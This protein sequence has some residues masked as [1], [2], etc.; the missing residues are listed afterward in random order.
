[1]PMPY[2]A[3][4]PGLIEQNV[5][6]EEVHFLGSSPKSFPA[7]H[8]PTYES[9]A[10]RRNYEPTSPVSLTS[11]GE[12]ELRPLGDI[13]LARSG[14]KGG[15]VNIGIFVHTDKEWDWLRSFLTSA[16]MQELV[17]DDWKPEFFIERIEF[18]HLKA[19]HFVI[20]GI[21]G[22]G[23]SSSSRLD[24]LGKAFGEYI[25]DKWVPVPVQFLK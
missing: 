12:T 7:G 3:Y 23:V 6:N 15:N 8:P 9:L 19:V 5:L 14:D 11:F 20:Y 21:L 22:R 16:K 10:P 1:M 4:F 25:R 24:A 2:L 17:G 18:V 13:A